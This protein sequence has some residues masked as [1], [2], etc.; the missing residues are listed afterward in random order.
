M[1]NE[2][3]EKEVQ[4]KLVDKDAWQL[5]YYKNAQ[6]A[7]FS[8]DGITEEIFK[9][10]LEVAAGLNKSIFNNGIKRVASTTT[11]NQIR[12][13]IGLNQLE[14]SHQR[15]AEQVLQMNNNLNV[16]V[17]NLN[18]LIA[19]QNVIVQQHNK[20]HPEKEAKPVEV[21]EPE[22]SK[23][24]KSKTKKSKVKKSKTKKSR[25]KPFKFDNL[26]NVQV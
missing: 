17:E 6:E 14:K 19:T 5:E 23:V 21:S 15:L 13:S 7:F 8:G 24:K 26:P 3:D 18:S 12:L 2:K 20:E 10:H 4:V 16:I 1:T 22:K 9:E 11:V 25:T